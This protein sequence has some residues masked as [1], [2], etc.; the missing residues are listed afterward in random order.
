ML[1]A[2]QALARQGQRL[3]EARRVRQDGINRQILRSFDADVAVL[4]IRRTPSSE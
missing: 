2:A 3:A 1:I 4:T